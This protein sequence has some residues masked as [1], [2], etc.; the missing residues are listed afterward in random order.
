MYI[1][2][3]I[4]IR[5]PNTETLHLKLEA[6]DS[7]KIGRSSKCDIVL[8]DPKMSGVHC[9]I[10]LEPNGKVMIKDLD[11]SNGTW[12]STSK[13]IHHNFKLGDI[14]RIG[15][16]YLQI[17]A[18]ELTPAERIK[19]GKNEVKGVD[20]TTVNRQVKDLQKELKKQAE[21]NLSL[22]AKLEFEFK[23]EDLTTGNL[24]LDKKK[25]KN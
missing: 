16:T 8:D 5:Q 9:R 2:V 21:E 22:R 13:I 24:K 19:I 15:Q 20:N 25:K 10:D 7:F 17:D 11:S 4:I 18:S 6:L 23:S 3:V 12:L 14:I 1:A